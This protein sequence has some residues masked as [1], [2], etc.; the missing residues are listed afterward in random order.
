VK[1]EVP[2]SMPIHTLKA[3]KASTRASSLFST[4]GIAFWHVVALQQS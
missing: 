3:L 4:P 2:L 1:A